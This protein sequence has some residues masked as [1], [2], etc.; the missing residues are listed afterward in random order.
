[1]SHHLITLTTDFGTDSPYVAQVKGVLLSQLPNAILVDITHAIPAQDIRQGA[2]VADDT[3]RY[4]SR[5]SIHLL[6]IDPGVGT[7]RGIVVAEIDGSFYVAPNNGLLSRVARRSPPS[8]AI[9]VDLSVFDQSSISPTFH[10]RD[11]MAP[12]VI[13]LAQGE[14][15]TTFGNRVDSLE[16]LDWVEPKV[17][18]NLLEGQI[19]YVD[20]FGNLVT[21]IE[22]CFLNQI[23]DLHRVIISCR[24]Q[25]I[26]GIQRTYG[27]SDPQ[28][29]IALV[30]S[31]GRVEL[32][33][34]DGNAAKQWSA[35]V[36]DE[37]AVNWPK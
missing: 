32:A 22:K 14:K 5:G 19:L 6:V 35:G 16:N 27:E 21:N 17:M 18:A 34:V 37:V 1:M 24:D 29:A 20:S 4:F 11:V 7:E 15:L 13:R 31:H 2:I 12:V 30:G 3:C 8:A 28:Q 26:T 9:L 36:G 33:V 25:R 23:Q 10:A